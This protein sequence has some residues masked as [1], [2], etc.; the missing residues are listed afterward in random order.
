MEIKT[1]DAVRI[2]YTGTLADGVVFDSSRERDPL[3]FVL[4]KRMIIEGIEK[5]LI[6]R[7]A[8]EHVRI[9]IPAAEAYGDVDDSLLFEVPLHEVPPHITPSAGLRLTLSAPEGDMDVTVAHVDK[10]RIVLDANHPL[11]GKSLAFEI[12]VIA[13][14]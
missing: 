12:E 10:D 8:G 6:G 5:A 1:G 7:K 4:G 3:E 13:V 11:A 14:K 2:H 9:T